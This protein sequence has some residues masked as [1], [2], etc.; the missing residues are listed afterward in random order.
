MTGEV[1]DFIQHALDNYP[2]S[3]QVLEIGAFDV[4]GSPRWHF[5]E[6]NEWTRSTEGELLARFP[7]YTGVDL[8]P[9]RGV[10]LVCS[11]HYLYYHFGPF[12]FDVII[13]AEMLEHDDA[14]WVTA[15]QISQVLRP[16]GWLILTVPGYSTPYH[17]P[18]DYF[19]YSLDGLRALFTG[20]E[21]IDLREV[22]ECPMLLARRGG[23]I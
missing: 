2:I 10:D 5:R 8:L 14:P 11:S 21:I 6:S 22:N 19:R 16:G 20:M 9:G 4:N 18:P 23:T 7:R 1:Q 12:S 17:H 13:C 15:Q 3:G